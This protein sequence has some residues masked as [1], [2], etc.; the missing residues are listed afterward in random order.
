MQ[1]LAKL[2]P[3]QLWGIRSHCMYKASNSWWITDYIN[4]MF[5]EGLKSNN[6]HNISLGVKLQILSRIPTYIQ[7]S[8]TKSKNEK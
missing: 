5:T 8:R 3:M 7:M 1:R 6:T 2:I 4:S